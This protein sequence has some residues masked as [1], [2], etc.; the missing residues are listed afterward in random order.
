MALQGLNGR[1]PG[2]TCNVGVI[3]AGNRCNVVAERASLEVDLRAA[4]SGGFV[5]ARAAVDEIVATI[6]VPEARS[7]LRVLHE[8]RPWER[9]PAGA[10]LVAE[11]R[12]TAAGLGFDVGDVATGGA[13]DANITAAA[14]LPSVD[15][16]GPIGGDAHGPAEWLDL[17]SIVPR[18]S[19]LAGFLARLGAGKP[20]A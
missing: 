19:L 13:G 7:A 17:D 10:A 15:G 1:W 18:V 6:A 11:I 5:E 20:A 8:H 14:G 12:A 16:L 9:T 4:T 2:V 3:R